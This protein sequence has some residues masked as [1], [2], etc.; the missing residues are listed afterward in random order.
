MT[1]KMG[2]VEKTKYKI[3][4]VDDHDVVREGL[5]RIIIQEK[6]FTVCG[7]ASDATEALKLLESEQP[8]LV[9]VDIALEGMNGIELTKIIRARFPTVRIL[10]L[11]MH[12]EALYAERAL[13][14]GSNGYIAKKESGRKLLGAIRQ[15]LQ[16]HVYVSEDFNELI[17]QKLSNPNRELGSFSIDVL[18]DRELEVFQLIGQGFGTRQIAEELKIS[19]KTVE[20]HREH[21]RAKCHL[22]A[23]FDLVQQAIYWVHQEKNM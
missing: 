22:A 14:A 4:V 6:D 3:L 8:D 10:T 9:I 17:L 7:L 1:T 5:S 15:V 18:S 2:P 12:K 20:A 11:S 23:N 16:G 13:R 19:M 21:I